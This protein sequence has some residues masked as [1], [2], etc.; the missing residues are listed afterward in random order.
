MKTGHVSNLS[1][2]K[3]LG[4]IDYLLPAY[5]VLSIPLFYL[6]LHLAFVFKA[7]GILVSL[8]Y[9]MKYGVPQTQNTRIFTIFV[10]LVTFSFFQ[11]LYNGKPISGY[12]TDI[13]NYVAAMLF[14]YIGASD[15]RPGRLFYK[16]LLYSTAI[17]FALGL[18]CYVLT[19]TW[20]VMRHLDMINNSSMVEYDEY[21]V[22]DKLRFSAFFDSYSVSHLSVF[23][24]A[25]AIFSVIYCKGREKMVAF[26]CLIV[27]LLSSVA[28]MHRA[29]MIGS[30]FAFAMYAYYNHRSKRVKYNIYLGLIVL[31]F[32]GIFL[33]FFSNIGDRA[34]TIHEMF[35]SRVDDNMSLGKALEER[36]FT[37]EL[38]ASMQFYIFGHGLGSGGVEMRAYGF[39]GVSD[40]QY[41]KMFYENGIVGAVLFLWIIYRS[42]LKGIKYIKIYITEVIII[43]FILVAMLGSNS[44]SI[45]Y[46]IV[47]P[48]WY[49]VGRIN[50][51]QYFKQAI[52][53]QL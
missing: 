36:K 30:L 48:F 28:S 14:F 33:Y 50:N 52:N 6:G 13:S 25:I 22:V 29:S 18:I 27:A 39:P 49:A 51:Y 8:L 24:S 10:L 23:A 15:E 44:L 26:I 46:F 11:Y 19:P 7:I 5:I 38:M 34:D 41:I 2:W 53:K 40:M 31:L 45:Y 42:L 32:A 47:F 9:I 1:R 17:V 16:K 43:L 3:M 35:T 4:F 20:Y 12:V 21:N 37:K